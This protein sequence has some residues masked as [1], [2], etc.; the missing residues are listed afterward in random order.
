V[1][2][3]ARSSTIALSRAAR[4]GSRNE[5]LFLLEQTGFGDVIVQGGHNDAEATSDDDFIVFI[6]RKR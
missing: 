2:Q 4:A 3:S 6:A 5:L 1:V